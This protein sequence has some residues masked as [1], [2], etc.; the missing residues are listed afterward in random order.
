MNDSLYIKIFDSIA[1]SN[2]MFIYKDL[3]L[4]I[5]ALNQKLNKLKIYHLINEVF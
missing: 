1:H 4:V 2:Q 5:K 3:F